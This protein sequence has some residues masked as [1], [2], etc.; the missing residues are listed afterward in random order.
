MMGE[1]LAISCVSGFGISFMVALIG[2]PISG[3]F[4]IVKL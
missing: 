4:K 1:I 3:F 2:V